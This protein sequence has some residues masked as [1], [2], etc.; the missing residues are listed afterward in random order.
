[1]KVFGNNTGFIL[2]SA[3]F[4][5]I[6]SCRKDCAF[7]SNAE[8][9]GYDMREC[10]CCGGLEI[11]IDKE[12]PPNAGSFFLISELPSYYKIGDNPAFPI[13]VKIDYRIDTTGCFGNFVKILKIANR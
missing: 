1:M 12:V 13:R 7:M 10:P 8:I 4:L 2:I 5:S 3:L 6:Q 9:I 11:T